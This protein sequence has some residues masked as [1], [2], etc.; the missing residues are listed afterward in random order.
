MDTF[1]SNHSYCL[2]SYRSKCTFKHV[3]PSVLPTR[4]RMFMSLWWLLRM[5]NRSVYM[6]LLSTNQHPGLDLPVLYR[7]TRRQQHVKQK[8]S[9][10]QILPAPETREQQIPA[11]EMGPDALRGAPQQ[12]ESCTPETKAVC[13]ASFLQPSVSRDL[14]KSLSFMI[15]INVEDNCAAQYFYGSGDTLSLG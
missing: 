13:S 8:P 4:P 5:I 10:A 6:I 9:D 1:C 11:A 2:A 15:I 14:Q 7:E 3:G 12:G